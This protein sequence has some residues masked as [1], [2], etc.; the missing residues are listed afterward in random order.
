MASLACHAAQV[1][2]VTDA[3]PLWHAPVVP[4]A[5]ESNPLRI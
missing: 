4:D 5:I 1:G 2:K 3:R